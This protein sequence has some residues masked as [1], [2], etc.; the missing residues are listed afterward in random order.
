MHQIQKENKEKMHKN[1]TNLSVL[2]IRSAQIVP[3]LQIPAT[4]MVNLLIRGI[5]PRII[6]HYYY[7]MVM[8]KIIKIS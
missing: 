6:G 8:T 5:L 7:Y 2:Q 1:V 3:G 4:F